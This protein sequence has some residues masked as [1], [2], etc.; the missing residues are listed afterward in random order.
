VFCLKILSV[1]MIF[2]RRL[3]VNEIWIRSISRRIVGKTG[4]DRS[5][6]INLTIVH[7]RGLMNNLI[8]NTNI[9]TNIKMWNF[10]PNLLRPQHVSIF[11]RP[12]SGS[13]HQTSIYKTKMNHQTKKKVSP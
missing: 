8:D 12:S 4:K 3:Q 1:S 2:G 9:G 10:A 6:R 5:T 7:I 11:F 13:L